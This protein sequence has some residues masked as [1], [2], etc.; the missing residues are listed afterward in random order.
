M[1][2]STSLTRQSQ[3]FYVLESVLEL[4]PGSTS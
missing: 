2:V 4:M 3:L 1:T